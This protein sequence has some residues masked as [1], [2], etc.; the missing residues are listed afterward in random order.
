MIEIKKML[1]DFEA[2]DERIKSGLSERDRLKAELEAARKDA[3]R[4]AEELDNCLE[5]L[6]P[7]SEYPETIHC[8]KS[9]IAAHEAL[10]GKP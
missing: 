9:A 7:S 8:I 4:L 5:H 2:M 6:E 3:D 10:R 1:E